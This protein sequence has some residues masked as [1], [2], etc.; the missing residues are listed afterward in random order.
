MLSKNKR[1]HIHCPRCIGGT[2]YLDGGDMICINCGC[3]ITR[4]KGMNAELEYDHEKELKNIMGAI[5][6]NPRTYMGGRSR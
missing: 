1:P 5:E 2:M 3:S 4:N 6:V